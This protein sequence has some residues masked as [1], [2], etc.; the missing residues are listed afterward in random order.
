MRKVATVVVVAVLV[1][2]ASA[3][4]VV[5]VVVVGLPV[6]RTSPRQGF[7]PESRVLGSVV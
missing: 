3:V 5:A 7:C 1:V 4:I 6:L 2:V